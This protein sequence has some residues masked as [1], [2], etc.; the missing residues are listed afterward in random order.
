MRPLSLTTASEFRALDKNKIS[1]ATRGERFLD[2]QRSRERM[3][4]TEPSPWAA[5]RPALAYD[6]KHGENPGNIGPHFRQPASSPPQP[7][8]RPKPPTSRVP[9]RPFPT[10][11]MP[12]GRMPIR[13]SPATD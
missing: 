3:R 10:R 1:E 8:R 4:A 11:F 13:K 9:A 12:N 6:R 7:L 5:R 2:Q